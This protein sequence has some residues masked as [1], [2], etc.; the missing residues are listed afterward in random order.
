MEGEA[1]D[2]NVDEQFAYHKLDDLSKEQI[3]LYKKEGQGI[4]N[5]PS[6]PLTQIL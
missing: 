2:V 3:D 6:S 1:D 4:K 5:S